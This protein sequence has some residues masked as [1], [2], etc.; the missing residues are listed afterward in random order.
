MSSIF[1]TQHATF[2]HRTA[3]RC[4]SAT[5]PLS[6]RAAKILILSHDQKKDLEVDLVKVSLWSMLFINSHDLEN[7][8]AFKK[9]NLLFWLR[10]IFDVI[11]FISHSPTHWKKSFFT[12]HW[13]NNLWTVCFLRETLVCISMVSS[14]P[15]NLYLLS[16]KVIFWTPFFGL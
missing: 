1:I 13:K 7:P 3:E 8:F 15:T 16:F 6:C 4:S 2:Q 11:P 5:W 12:E 14:L 10:N 9:R